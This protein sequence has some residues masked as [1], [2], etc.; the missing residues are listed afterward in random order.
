MTVYIA[1]WTPF[2]LACALRSL[3][4]GAN[5]VGNRQQNRAALLA[6]AITQANTPSNPPWAKW[7]VSSGS[8]AVTKTS[9]CALLLNVPLVPHFVPPVG[10][11]DDGT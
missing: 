10:T 3:Q 4:Q 6:A 8:T 7:R 11:N 9:S 1:K 2:R 5:N